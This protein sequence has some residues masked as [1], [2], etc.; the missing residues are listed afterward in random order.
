M[1]MTRSSVRGSCVASRSR[2][3]TLALAVIALLGP[4]TGAHPVHGQSADTDRGGPARS[5]ALL[6]SRASTADRLIL[7]QWSWHVSETRPGISNDRIVGLVY[8]AYFAG[9]FRTSHGGRA[10]AVGIEREWA[11]GEAG[12]VGFVLGYRA[13]AFY[14]YDE[15]LG[16]LAAAVPVLPFVS[17]LV[18][19]HV[20]PLT[21]ELT[22]TWVVFSLT[23]GV[24]F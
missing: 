10:Y 19:W 9:T 4:G 20:G 24:R 12:P 22:H 23:A 21:A 5:P 15:Q 14:G 11:S 17:P 13:G 2:A 7:A 1:R 18:Y 3:A 8:Y 6:W 16:W